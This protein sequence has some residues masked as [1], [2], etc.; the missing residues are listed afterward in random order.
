MILSSQVKWIHTAKSLLAIKPK[1]QE[2]TQMQVQVFLKIGKH[3]T[4]NQS[5]SFR[6]TNEYLAEIQVWD[7]DE[8]SKDDLVG[9]TSIALQKYLVDTPIPAEW[10][11]LSYKVI[12]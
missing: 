11:N 1:E 12:K 5:L 7:S 10:I 6:R 8:V 4:W 9:E 3:P 2:N